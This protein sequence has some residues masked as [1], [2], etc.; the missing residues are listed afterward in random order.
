[1][2]SCLSSLSTHSVCRQRYIVQRLSGH[3]DQGTSPTSLPGLL[4][5]RNHDLSASG[6]YRSVSQWPRVSGPCPERYTIKLHEDQAGS[7]LARLIPIFNSSQTS[8]SIYPSNLSESFKECFYVRADPWPDVRLIVVPFQSHS[9]PDGLHHGA[10]L[11]Q[12][13][14]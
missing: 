1:M 13:T 9:F 5:R 11:L 8:T 6:T 12:C 7:H 10:T 14:R 3:I 4:Y 2:S